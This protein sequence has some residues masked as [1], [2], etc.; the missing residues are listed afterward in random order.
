V[1][2]DI[3]EDSDNLPILRNHYILTRNAF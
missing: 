1:K 3:L 2:P